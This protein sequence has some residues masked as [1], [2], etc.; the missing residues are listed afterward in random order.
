[1]LF[2]KVSGL[3]E[4]RMDE[5]R[6]TTR[7]ELISKESLTGELGIARKGYSCIRMVRIIS[8]QSEILQLMVLVL[9]C[10]ATKKWSTKVNG[11]TADLMDEAPNCLRMEATLKVP[12]LKVSSKARECLNGLTVR[13]ILGI[14]TKETFTEKESK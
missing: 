13:P 8:E 10:I 7:M 4:G 2:T 11:L 14:S 3:K 12:L 5:A 1:M 9:W 6:F